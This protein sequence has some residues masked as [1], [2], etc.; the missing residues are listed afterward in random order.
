MNCELIKLMRPSHWVKNVFIFM[1]VFF[2]HEMLNTQL[3]ANSALMFLSF[4][5]IASAVYCLNDMIDLEADRRHPVKCKRPIASGAVSTGLA[6]MLMLALTAL[7]FAVLLLLP[8]REFIIGGCCTIL[9]YLLMEL[10]Y[11]T[12]LKRYAIID[13]CILSM[14]FVLRIIAGGAVTGIIISHWLIMMTFLLTLF[15]GIAK[16]RDDVLRMNATGI[17]PRHNTGRYNLTFVNNALNITG[18][19]TMVCYIMYTVSPEVTENFGTRYLYLT[20]IFVL[21]GLLRYIQLAVVDERTGD[22]TKVLLRD[23]FT[24]F[25]IAGWVLAFLIIIYIV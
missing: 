21:V 13:I 6:T 4:C 17:A 16:R 25:V 24:Q 23:R 12:I 10:A 19:V 2:G 18:A 5:F 11:C 7:S 9:A 8:E 15:L 3:L 1:P 20:S 22:P 14:G